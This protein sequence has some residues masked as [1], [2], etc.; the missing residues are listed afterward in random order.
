M[1]NQEL[2]E[3]TEGN[4]IELFY[5]RDFNSERIYPATS[6]WE[7]EFRFNSLKTLFMEIKKF[8]KTASER[9]E[10]IGLVLIA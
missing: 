5:K 4:F 7:K 2:E 8:F 10:Y 9:G 1:I 6:N 3:V